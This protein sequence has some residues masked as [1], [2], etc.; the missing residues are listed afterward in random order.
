MMLRISFALSNFEFTSRILTQHRSRKPT[1]PNKTLAKM[2]TEGHPPP[3]KYIID[4]V[5]NGLS[6]EKKE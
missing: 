5:Q 1:V 2:D 6:K 3:R 4:L